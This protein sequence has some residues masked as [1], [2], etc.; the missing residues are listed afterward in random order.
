LGVDGQPVCDKVVGVR[1]GHSSFFEDDEWP[2]FHFPVPS[3]WSKK[4]NWRVAWEM[5]KADIEKTD[6][7][8]FLDSL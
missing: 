6:L 3:G 7:G 1:E 8:V 4:K 2:F 5:N